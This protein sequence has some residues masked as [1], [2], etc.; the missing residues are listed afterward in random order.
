M[1]EHSYFVYI[2]ASKTHVLYCGVTND[3]IRRVAQHKRGEFPGFSQKY[4]CHR[5]VW[6]E[7]F[8]YVGNAITREKQIKKWNRAKKLDRIRESNPAW[9]DL[10]EG[11]F[12]RISQEGY[13]VPAGINERETNGLLPIPEKRLTP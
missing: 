5:L 3:L 4:K 10:S 1:K 11:W 2:M 13:F 9:I 7:H 12:D 6:F 8:Q